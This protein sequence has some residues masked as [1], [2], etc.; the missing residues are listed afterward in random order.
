MTVTRTRREFSKAV[1]RD[2]AHRANGK[3][4][5]CG[6]RLRFGDYHY[7]H[8]DPDAVGGGNTLDNCRVLCIDCHK[9]KTRE[10]DLP[11]IV[12]SR[13]QRDMAIGIRPA[14]KLKSRGFEPRPKQHSATRELRSR[15]MRTT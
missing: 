14:P 3:C 6:K 1:K 13:G 5:G 10:R 9:T 7:D 2:A 4:E 12:K 15:N 11:R 8:D